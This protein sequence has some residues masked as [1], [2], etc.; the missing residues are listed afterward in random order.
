MF[1]LLMSLVAFCGGCATLP[2][3]SEVIE[4]APATQEPPQILSARGFL[5]PERSKALMERLKRS[6]EPTDLLDRHIA[7]IE[8]ASE[9]PL[10]KG[11]KVSLLIDGPA[12]YAAMFGAV[13]AAKDHINLETFIIEDDETGRMFA[14][15]LLQKQSE[16]IQVN[17]IYDS[18]GSINTPPAFFQ[19][20]R[21]VGIQ[22]LEFN[23]INPLKAHGKW[24]LT[25]R[26]H[27]KILIVDG[28]FVVTGG[29]N[30]SEVYSGGPSG[31][32]QKKDGQIPWR[33][34]DVSIEGP[35]V[36]EFQRIFL[37]S[38]QSQ[39]GPKLPERN[40]FPELKEAGHDLVQVIDSTPGEMNRLT[41]IMY[42]SAVN[43]AENF[44][45]LSTPILSPT[46]SWFGP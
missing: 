39:K 35:A 13:G 36:V 28:K 23:P 34:T 32:E 18:V 45:H 40:Y 6:V 33:D 12:T 30:I 46:S 11:N 7:V 41:F 10:I 24:R 8:S 21:D 19:R 42:V 17:I 1:L 29:V 38:W 26:D 44:V 16:G 9:H 15:L 22:V 5:S 20:L 3:V 27:R 25:N 43:F 14:D 31:S 37:S 2:K 4:G